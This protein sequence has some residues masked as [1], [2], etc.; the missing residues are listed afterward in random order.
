MT[1]MD[2]NQ[3]L[4]NHLRR[5]S[6]PYGTPSKADWEKLAATFGCRF[7][8]DFIMFSNVMAD[9]EGLGDLL[10]VGEGSNV[11]TP[12]TIALVHDHETRIGGWPPHLVPFLSVGNGD[13]FCL[14]AREGIDSSVYY[15]Y[16]EDRRVEK[17]AETFADW[18]CK[19]PMLVA[20]S[21]R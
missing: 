9:Y 3:I 1:Q 7:H 19:I 13:Y 12:D 6:P 15:C 18:I 17:Y 8:E 5:Q 4:Q 2:I 20:G 21:T 14:D 16:H 10:S 11:R